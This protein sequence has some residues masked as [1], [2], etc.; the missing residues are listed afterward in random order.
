M[1]LCQTYENALQKNDLMPIKTFVGTAFKCCFEAW[2][3]KG[4][5]QTWDLMGIE[6]PNNICIASL[7]SPTEQVAMTAFHKEKSILDKALAGKDGV[8]D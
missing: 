5:W 3:T 2:N 4:S 1:I 8:K 6:N 7:M